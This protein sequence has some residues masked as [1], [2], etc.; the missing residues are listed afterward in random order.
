MAKAEALA[1][2]RAAR[3]FTAHHLVPPHELLSEEETPGRSAVARRD[4]RAASED[5]HRATRASRPTRGTAR[6]ARRRSRSRGGWSGSGVPVR[7]GGRSDRLPGRSSPAGGVSAMREIVDAF[8]RERSI[9]NHHLASFNDFLPTNDNPNS[10]MQRIV[11][12]SRV[13]EDSTERGDHPPRRPEDEELH[14]RA[15]RPPPRPPDRPGRRHRGADDLRRPAVREGAGRLQAD[16][17]A[18]WR[19]ASGTSPTRP[20]STC[21]SPSSRTAS[22]A[23]PRTSTS[24]TSRSWSRAGPCNLA[25]GEHRARQRRPALRGGVPR[26]ARRVRRGPARPRRLLHHRR[27]RA[28]HHE[29]RGPRAEPDLRR[30]Q[31]ALRHARSRA[32]RCSASAADTVRSP[33][34]RRRR[35]ASSRSPSPRASGQIPLAILMKALGMKNDEEIYQAVLGRAPPAGR[36]VRPD[37]EAPAQRQPRGVRLEEAL[38]ARGDP[39]HRGRAPLPREEVRDRPGQGVPPAEGRRHPRPLAPPAPRR[40]QGATA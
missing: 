10:R 27:D 24:A 30:V 1:A 25:P 8:F 2:A 9:V 39:D 15:R 29:P 32:R 12:E 4:R 37:D 7:D 21:A 26:E 35:T 34:S 28:R 16:A 6:P 20:R 11:D 18:R 13:S 14:L 5:P 19:R 36:A 31:R 22:S 3:P 40:H 23:P 38:P 17:D 33:S